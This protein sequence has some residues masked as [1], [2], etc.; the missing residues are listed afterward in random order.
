M[1][2]TYACKI[3]SDKFWDLLI[4]KILSLKVKYFLFDSIIEADSAISKAL[5]PN[6]KFVNFNKSANDDLSKN[7]WVISIGYPIGYP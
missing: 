6:G 1:L 3:I 7:P 2:W 5:L 4:F